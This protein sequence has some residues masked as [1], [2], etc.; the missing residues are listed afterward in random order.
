[1]WWYTHVAGSVWNILKTL[2][3][4]YSHSFYPHITS[5][6]GKYTYGGWPSDAAVKCAHSASAAQS[7]QVRIPGADMAPL[8]KPCYSRHPTYKVKEDG[9]GC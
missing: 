7:S 5:C 6:Y 3:G 8:G 9:H 1:M 2:S 4:A